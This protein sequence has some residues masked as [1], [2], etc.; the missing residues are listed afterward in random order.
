L[1]GAGDAWLSHAIDAIALDRNDLRVP[2]MPISDP[3][4]FRDK[5]QDWTKRFAAERVKALKPALTADLLAEFDREPTGATRRHSPALQRLLVFVRSAPIEGK[6]FIYAEKPDEL[7]RLA[8]MRGR[9]RP[10]QIVEGERYR[11]EAEAVRAVFRRRLA[12]LGLIGA[13]EEPGT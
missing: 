3:R 7:Y 8:L 9:G 4:R 6:M 5:T 10:P 2:L 11:T 13:G 12:A 1:I